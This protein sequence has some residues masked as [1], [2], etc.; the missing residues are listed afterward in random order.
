MHPGC[1]RGVVFFACSVRAGTRR[2]GRI[3]FRREAF[4]PAAA[5]P[6][7]AWLDFIAAES[8]A[9]AKEVED[10]LKRRVFEDV[11][12]QLAAGFLEDRRLR[13]GDRSTPDEA[14]LEDIRQATLTLLYRILFLLYAEA[15]DLLPVRESPYRRLSLT[16]IKREIADAAGVAQTD[17]DKKLAEAYKA[18]AT[19]LYDRL[20]KLFS[21]MDTGD[22]AV[23]VPK[24]N[25]GLFLMKPNKPGKK[26]AP[27]APGTPGGVSRDVV[28]AR[29][30]LEHKVPDRFLAIAIDRLARVM[31]SRRFELLFIDY[32][33]LGVRH[34][35][36]IYEGLL[37]FKLKIAD[38]D[39][40][41]VKEK[42]KEVVIP[43]AKA[44]GKGKSGRK[45]QVAVPK[46]QPYLANDKSERKATGSYYTPDH[47]VEYIVEN[48]VGPV[49]DAK[50]E[51]LRPEFRNAEQT[52]H[53]ARDNAEKNP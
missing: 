28:I 36:S 2:W 20:L 47:I 40:A 22:A 3:F 27:G 26:G 15:R 17:A 44:R 12:P 48:A 45:L 8:R 49:L 41:A 9:Y 43:L 51:A 25:G 1:S 35:G 34:L 19:D 29:F 33:S 16:Q 52:Y 4:E 21:V 46:G 53:R 38:E 13:L 24:Y 30:L 14:E 11:V 5:D 42:G 23:N 6:K 32:K 50:L 37:E 39:L 18:K 31:D 7:Q 10:R